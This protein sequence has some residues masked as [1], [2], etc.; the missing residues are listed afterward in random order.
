MAKHYDDDDDYGDDDGDYYYY[1]Y[2]TSGGRK[3]RKHK[4]SFVEFFLTCRKYRGQRINAF[5]TFKNYQPMSGHQ[6][7]Q[8]TMM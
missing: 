8:L 5:R 4:E 7:L 6:T 3:F 1:Y 2:Y